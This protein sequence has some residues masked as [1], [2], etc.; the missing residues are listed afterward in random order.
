MRSGPSYRTFPESFR[1]LAKDAE[2]LKGYKGSEYRKAC[3]RQLIVHHFRRNENDVVGCCEK[4]IC[5]K[6]TQTPIFSVSVRCKKLIFILFKANQTVALCP[7]ECTR[8]WILSNDGELPALYKV[9]AGQVEGVQYRLM[10]CR[11]KGFPRPVLHIR[12]L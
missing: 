6:E 11:T 2:G 10:V 12:S 3:S 1:S 4:E 7:C 9:C 8:F 5:M